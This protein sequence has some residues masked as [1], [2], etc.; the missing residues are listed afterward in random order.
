[1]GCGEIVVLVLLVEVAS[2]LLKIAQ[3]SSEI[4]K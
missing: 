2:L 4:K 3:N 1:M